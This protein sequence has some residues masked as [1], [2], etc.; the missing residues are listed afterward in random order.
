MV[1]LST[2]KSLEFTLN[3]FVTLVRERYIVEFPRPAN[4]TLGRHVK[5]VRIAHSTDFIRPA[6]ISVPIADAA[7]V[8][9]PTTVPSDP[10]RTPV[11]GTRKLMSPPSDWLGLRVSVRWRGG[12]APSG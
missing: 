2:T 10:S 5:E 12:G 7:V 9:D 1:L 11:V 4:A 6:G 3:R 8:N